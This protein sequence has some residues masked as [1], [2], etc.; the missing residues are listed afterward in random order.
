MMTRKE[1]IGLTEDLPTDETWLRMFMERLKEKDPVLYNHVM[2]GA[3]ERLE[4]LK[5]DK[6]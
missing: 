4:E 2:V 6:S 1:I 5:G 3:K